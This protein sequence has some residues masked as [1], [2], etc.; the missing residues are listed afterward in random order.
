MVLIEWLRPKGKKPTG[1]VVIGLVLGLAGIAL[2]VGPSTLAGTARVNPTGATVLMVGSFCWAAGSIYARYGRVPDVPLMATG[3]QMLVGGACL[4][5][6]AAITGEFG[7]LDLAAVSTRSLLA[8]LYL[9]VF[10]SIIGYTAYVWLLRVSTPARVS[11]YA[12]VNPIVAVALGS[13]FA[14]EPLTGRMLIAAAVIVA[15]VALITASPEAH[16]LPRRATRGR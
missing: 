12:Y 8:M 10:G 14:K 4:L 5:G 11:T 16:D 13:I 9:L 7:E 2:L 1:T 15:G 3:M 6:A